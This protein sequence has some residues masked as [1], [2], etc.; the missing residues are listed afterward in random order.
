MITL[1]TIRRGKRFLNLRAIAI[2]A[3]M[4]PDTFYGRVRRGS[5]EFTVR[6]SMNINAIFRG[7]GDQATKRMEADAIE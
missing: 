7:I 6:E 2:E 3:G 5:P 1:E 4:N